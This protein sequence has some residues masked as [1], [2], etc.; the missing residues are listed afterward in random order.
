M[1][2]EMCAEAGEPIHDTSAALPMCPGAAEHCCRLEEVDL[3]S[4][5]LSEPVLERLCQRC[6]RLTSVQLPKHCQPACVEVL[7]RRLPGLRALRLEGVDVPAG[8]LA[9]LP[10]GLERLTL[11]G[12]G[13][14]AA[15]RQSA[16]RWP[17]LTELVVT[18][19]D[20]SGLAALVAGCPRLRRLQADCSD[21]DDDLLQELAHLQQLQQLDISCE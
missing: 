2:L 3:S 17:R 7:L 13:L 12:C 15:P 4:F 9:L 8:L 18:L 6:P 21:A 11:Y 19:S 10:P 5:R 1:P 20:S 16:D 14:P